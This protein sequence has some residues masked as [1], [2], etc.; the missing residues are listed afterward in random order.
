MEKEGEP[1]KLFS[2][3]DTIA[4]TLA[5]LGVPISEGDV[6]RKFV[7]VLTHEYE[8]EQRAPLYRDELTRPE[9]DNIVRQ[10]YLIR[11]VS[12]GKNVGHDHGFR[13]ESPEV[14]AGVVVG[15]AVVVVMDPTITKVGRGT[16]DRRVAELAGS[17]GGNNPPAHKVTIPRTEYD[18]AKGK[19]IRCLQP[20]HM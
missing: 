20:G 15:V 7:R 10:R 17:K 6:N 1:I 19:C 3:V 12:K 18:K 9:I 4:S 8:I 5:S 16:R 11:S 2:R 14:V 13:V